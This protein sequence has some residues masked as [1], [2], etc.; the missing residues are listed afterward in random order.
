[1]SVKDAAERAGVSPSLI[2]EWCDERRLAHYRVGGAGKRGKIAIEQ[3]DLDAFLATLKV[4]VGAAP[5]PASRRK[6]KHLT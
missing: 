1:M 3:S 5:A 6:F 2:Y 4:E